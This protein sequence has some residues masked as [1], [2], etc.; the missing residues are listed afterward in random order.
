MG[1]IEQSGEP[2]AFRR[3]SA[4]LIDVFLDDLVPCA[5][6]LLTELGQLVLGVLA[7]VI[8]RYTGVDR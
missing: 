6:A 7:F 5:S 2:L 8:G 1:I 4:L 3:S